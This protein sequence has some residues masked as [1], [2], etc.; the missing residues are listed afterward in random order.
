MPEKKI[1]KEVS[2]KNVLVLRKVPQSGRLVG[3]R[4]NEPITKFVM[5]RVNRRFLE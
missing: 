2:F 3:S 5:S 1:K 4:Y